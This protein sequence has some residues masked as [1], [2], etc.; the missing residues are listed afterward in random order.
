MAATGVDEVVELQSSQTLVEVGSTGV[1]VVVVVVVLDQS[2]HVCAEATATRPAAA[3]I[4]RILIDGL[5]NWG[6]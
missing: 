1:V 2:A 4:E 6:N 3:A 5:L